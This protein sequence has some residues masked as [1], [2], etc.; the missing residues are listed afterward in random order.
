MSQT[1]QPKTP[2]INQLAVEAVQKIL[3]EIESLKV[4]LSYS[5]TPEDELNAINAIKRLNAELEIQ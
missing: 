3:K 4:Q 1:T 2:N 5:T